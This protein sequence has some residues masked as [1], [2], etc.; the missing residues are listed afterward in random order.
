VGHRL[1]KIY[2]RTGDSG[3]TVLGNGDR[4]SKTDLRIAVCGTVDET[5][6]AVGLVLAE[7]VADPNI[8]RSLTR[9][10]N[11]LFDLGAELTLPERPAITADHV[12]SIE[13]DLDALNEALPPLKEFIL[14]GGNRAAACC[15]MARAIARRAERLVWQLA[16]RTPVNAELLQYLNRLSDY[17]FVAA[18]CLA[19]QSGGAEVLWTNLRRPSGSGSS[20]GPAEQRTNG[21]NDQP[22]E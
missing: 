2:T 13:N 16:Q 21:N 6:C 12:T 10:Q 15:H 8:R 22:N 18:R 11:E 1:S 7:D 3:T 19:R 20:N 17:L 4:V 9:I 5:N 14:P